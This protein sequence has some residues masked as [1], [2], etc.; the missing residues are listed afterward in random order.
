M[1]D[2]RGAQFAVV[3]ASGQ[4]LGGCGINAINREH[5][6]ANLGY[7][8]RS[9]AAGRGVAPQAVRLVSAWAFAHTDLQRL[10]IVVAVQNTRSV[11]VAEKSGAQLEGLLR[12]RLRMHGR[13][14]DARMYA[15][16]R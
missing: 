11:R 16:I 12:A 14:H 13:V 9:S 8:I 5:G 3:S 6:F 2:G 7:W 4:Y 1:E 10:E 15:L